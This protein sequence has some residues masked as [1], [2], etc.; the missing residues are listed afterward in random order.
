MA[1]PK[2]TAAPKAVKAEETKAVKAVKEEV[3]EEVKAV[4][5]VAEAKAETKAAAPKKAAKKVSIE[6]QYAD[7]CFDITS[8]E[9][10]AVAAWA[11]ETGKTKTSAK[12]INIYVK[13]EECT[14]YYVIEGTAGKVEL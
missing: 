13:P 10:K 4:E 6:L 2:K 11:A 1:R 8:I 12:D 5:T 9:T 3:K 7:K 14:A